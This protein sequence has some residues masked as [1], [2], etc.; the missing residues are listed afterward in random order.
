MR[1]QTLRQ[2]Q[3]D[4][5]TRRIHALIAEMQSVAARFRRGSGAYTKEEVDVLLADTERLLRKLPNH[6]VEK[7]F[8]SWGLSAEAREAFYRDAPSNS[9]GGHR[10]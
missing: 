1:N 10:A 9:E 8:D 3:R 4:D 2:R 5:Y 7:F 6:L